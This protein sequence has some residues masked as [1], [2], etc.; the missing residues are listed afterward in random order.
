MRDGV[1]RG[2]VVLA[3]VVLS[4]PCSAEE[5]G[6]NDAKP[7]WQ[8]DGALPVGWDWIQ[9][10]SEEWLKGELVALYDDDLEFDSDE[11]DLQTFAWEDVAEVRTGQVM[12]VGLLGGEVVVGKLVIVGQT[13]RV[14]REGE[15]PL[16]LNRAEIL[17][18]TSGVPTKGL[19]RWSSKV[20]LG[21]TLRQ[22]NVDQLD[23]NVNADL[24]R[25]TAYDRVEIEYIAN[26]SENEE[27]ET[28]HNQR[29]SGTWDHFLTDRF[30]VKPVVTEWYRDLFQNIDSRS[31]LGAGVG[32][33]L[34]DTKRTEWT[35][36]T[37]LAYQETRF[38][39]VEA[40]EDA[41][42]ATGV[43][44]GSTA[45]EQEWTDDVDFT[46]EY[47][48]QLTNE[49]SGRYNHHMLLGVETEWTTVLDFD[50][51]L[52]WDRTEQPQPGEDGIVPEKD[53]FRMVVAL[54]FEF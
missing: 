50:V 19:R 18:I 5:P 4:W 29:A 14:H 20:S 49:V 48:F 25:R 44:I 39:E 41:S 9:L 45:F 47:R 31:T 6:G 13:V 38:V 51:T 10:T 43:F 24:K 3:L 17:T 21:M 7:R 12:E 1:F 32:Y 22:G 16:E 15:K 8:Q 11:L 28:V 33:Q 2:T 53:D 37:G 54:G 40:G 42:R 27:V 34:L 23:T 46:L 35:V 36:S 30:F 26:F 52:V